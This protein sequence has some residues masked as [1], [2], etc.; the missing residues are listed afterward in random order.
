MKLRMCNC[1]Q[2]RWARRHSKWER[3]KVRHAKKAARHKVKILIHMGRYDKLPE[4]I[5]I[6]YNG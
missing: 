6:P 3:Y 4:A 5:W 2:C 1:R